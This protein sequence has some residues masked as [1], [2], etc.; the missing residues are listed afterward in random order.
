MQDAQ[1]WLVVGVMLAF[2]CG[3]AQGRTWMVAED[4]SGDF[5]KL[6]EGYVAAGSGDSILIARRPGSGCG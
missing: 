5:V 6:S 1:A 4:G 2:S 3:R